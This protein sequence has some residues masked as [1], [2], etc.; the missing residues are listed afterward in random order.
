MIVLRCRHLKVKVLL[1]PNLTQRS[2]G[3]FPVAVPY[4]GSWDGW[5]RSPVLYCIWGYWAIRPREGRAGQLGAGQLG[6]GQL[7]AGQLTLLSNVRWHHGVCWAIPSIVIGRRTARTGL[8]IMSIWRTG[9]TMPY[10]T[11]YNFMTT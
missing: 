4:K 7:G 1:W 2:P 11:L 8:C 5:C 6:A 3:K 9:S 10:S